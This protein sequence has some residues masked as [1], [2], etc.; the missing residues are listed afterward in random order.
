MRILLLISLIVAGAQPA[1]GQDTPKPP[2]ARISGR[3]VAADTGKPIRWATVRLVSSQGRQLYK[4]TDVQGRFLFDAL[5]AGSYRLDARADRYVPMDFGGR[6]YTGLSAVAQKPITIREGEQFDRADLKLPRGGAIEGR[7]LD[8]F[9]DPAP[10][11]MVQL[12]QVVYAGGRQRLMPTGSRDRS[13]LSDD[14]GHFRIHGI[15]PGTYYLSVLSGV[16]AEQ[17]EAG[18]FAPTY[19]PGSTDLSKAQPLT[20]AAGQ[21]IT[22]LTFPLTPARMARISGRAVDEAGNPV[23]GASLMLATADGSGVSD[24][25]ITRAQGNPDG[26]FVLRNVPPGRF[27]LQ[28]F[29][30]P[31]AGGPMNLAAGPFGS[32]PLT[33][34]GEDQAGLV[35]RITTGPSLIGR[36]VSDD[37]TVPLANLFDVHV[38]AFPVEFNTAPVAGGPSPYEAKEDGTF[39]VKN[40]SGQRVIRV[41]VRNPRWMLKRVMRGGRDVTDEPIDFTGKDAVGDVEVVL[42]NRVT[43]I[44]GGVTDERGEPIANYSVLVFAVDPSKWTD[45][46][47][48]VTTARPSQDGTFIVRG[49]PPDDYY[50]I[51]LEEALGTE[52]QDPEFLKPLR[53]LATGVLL[54]DGEAEKLTLKV[55]RR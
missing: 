3:V 9:G 24:F 12:S 19:F 55:V 30:R 48:F 46:S 26:T 4:S 31:P 35:L 44:E 27:T 34:T 7:L 37:P 22:N 13:L 10:G 47:R 25:L 49:L 53:E 33:V 51:A 29:G 43:S 1:F 38:G 28:G 52:W 5:A 8:E 20:V 16:F 36:I 21:E 15:T 14:R 41:S 18:G 11:L 40:L 54:G 17:A 23:G 42:T 45:R 39:E 6:P 32:L 50:V 2:T